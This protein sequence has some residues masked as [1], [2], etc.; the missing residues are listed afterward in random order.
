MIGTCAKP[1]EVMGI[2]TDLYGLHS[3]FHY[4]DSAQDRATK[5]A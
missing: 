3:L 2:L 1:A 5:A 4:Q